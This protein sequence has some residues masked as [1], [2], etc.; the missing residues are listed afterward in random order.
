MN[1]SRFWKV[2]VPRVMSTYAVAVFAILWVGFAL[3]LVVDR[4]W[5][6]FLW[7][8]VRGLPVAAEVAVWVLFL[9]ITAGLGVWESSWS[10]LPRLLAFAGIVVWTLVAIVN[11]A[12]AAK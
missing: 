10:T 3:A 7:D 2:I 8:W 1:E 6:G 11:F 9:P 12:R 4:E 5:L